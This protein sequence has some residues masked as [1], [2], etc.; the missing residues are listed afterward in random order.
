MVEWP[1]RSHSSVKGTRQPAM[2]F[3]KRHL[4]SQ[5]MRNN[6]LWSTETKVELFGLNSKHHIWKKPGTILMVKHGGGS[7]ML[8][9]CFST[10]GTGEIWTEQSTERSSMKTCSREDSRL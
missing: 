3:A 6:I 1:D 9:G 4:D 2:E 5:T 7:I 8:W 10:A